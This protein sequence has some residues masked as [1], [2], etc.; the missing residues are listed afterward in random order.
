VFRSLAASWRGKPLEDV[1]IEERNG[2]KQLCYALLYGAGPGRI[3]A[4]SGCTLEHARYMYSDFLSRHK[5]LTQ[6][7]DSV[8]KS[9]KSTGFVETLLGRRRYLPDI[10]STDAEKRSRAERQVCFK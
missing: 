3:A 6:Y 7:M 10:R 9:C 8:K 5:C 1:T 2:I 4:D